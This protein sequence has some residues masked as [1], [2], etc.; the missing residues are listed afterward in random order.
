MS[1]TLTGCCTH[2]R[3]SLTKMKAKSNKKSASDKQQKQKTKIAR[4]ESWLLNGHICQSKLPSHSLAEG[5]D[6]NVSKNLT[7]SN[8]DI[9][10]S[11]EHHVH[12]APNVAPT[13]EDDSSQWTSPHPLHSGAHMTDSGCDDT[14]S[15]GSSHTSGIV[16]DFPMSPNR[17]QLPSFDCPHCSRASSVTHSLP[18]ESD[19]LLSNLHLYSDDG[20]H[21]LP[22]CTC[23]E[24]ANSLLGT[25]STVSSTLCPSMGLSRASSI[26]NTYS[27]GDTVINEPIDFYQSKSQLSQTSISRQPEDSKGSSKVRTFYRIKEQAGPEPPTNVFAYLDTTGDNNL[28]VLKWTPVRYYT[29]TYTCTLV[30]QSTMS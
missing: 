26:E 30:G 20:F 14:R 18:R 15:T 23:H 6:V 10:S 5:L 17:K 9:F 22:H 19:V 2:C 4:V 21:T 11:A 27:A 8:S 28:L 3:H 1:I 29:K 16:T 25:K 13:Y 7:S 12:F 24:E